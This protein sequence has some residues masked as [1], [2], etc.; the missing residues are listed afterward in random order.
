MAASFDKTCAIVDLAPTAK[1]LSY[2]SGR[3]WLLWPMWAYRVIVPQPKPE[4]LNLFQ[5]AV[6][7]LCRA[8][9][10]HAGEIAQ[11]L[12]FDKELAAYILDQLEGM[13]LLDRR[14]Q[15]TERA[16]QLLAEEPDDQVETT[17]G[18]V[19]A[20]PFIKELWPRFRRGVLPYAEGEIR[21]RFATIEQGTV[22][23]P[24][25]VE[26][27]VVW[28]PG[29]ACPPPP[30]RR[31]ILRACSMGIRAEVAYKRSM[32]EDSSTLD[33][34][35]VDTLK[36]HLNHVVLVDKT[37]EPMFLTTFV[38]VPK[39]VRR[40]S[41]W[42]VCDPFGLG[43]SHLLRKRIEEL[44]SAASQARGTLRDAIERATGVGF[45]VED[46]DVLD[47]VRAQNKKAAE[48]VDDKA[49]FDKTICPEVYERLVQM[50][51]KYLEAGNGDVSGKTWD[52]QQRRL[53]A[54]VR[55]AYI[56][57]E[58][59]LA[60]A[61]KTFPASDVWH[62]LGGTLEDNGVLLAE[63][64]YKI[65]FE[66]D[67]DD[68]CFKRFLRVGSGPVKGVIYHE[69]RELVALLAA[70]L[71][72]ANDRSEHPLRR[73]AAEFPEMIVFLNGLK[74]MR[75]QFSH[76]IQTQDGLDRE[77]ALGFCKDTYRVAQ[78]LLPTTEGGTT[79]SRSQF[80]SAEWNADI[81]YRL[82]AQA[83]YNVESDAL[84]GIRVQEVPALRDEL[85]E[86]ELLALELEKL[87]N[88]G[89]TPEEMDGRAKDLR[90]AAGNAVEAAIK[91]LL[92]QADVSEFITS[93]R[94]ANAERYSEAAEGLGFASMSDGQYH[95]DLLMVRPDRARLAAETQCGALNA[96]LMV[97]LLQAEQDTDHPLREVKKKNPRFLLDAGEVSQAR[98]HGDGRSNEA[99]GPEV[100]KK[101]VIAVGKAVLDVL[102]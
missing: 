90:V 58:E 100:L 93:D 31:D 101:H 102:T 89:A 45:A 29:D 43:T 19:F 11:R 35:N 96:L 91:P 67:P 33:G 47:L 46:V 75:D 69:Q 37:P 59:C 57:L 28:P 60:Y 83:A 72:A 77:E 41:L 7:S 18:Y 54:M 14:K 13:G 95:E 79:G 36:R 24:R 97:A 55:R 38:F 6:L 50:E 74:R 64:A 73:C 10:F 53:K 78:L 88:A 92:T 98:G 3:Q 8:G 80:S 68:P 70:A 62:P 87:R 63:I 34:L 66:D 56:V 61:V 49:D 26:M 40:A 4:R 32:E 42:Q 82:R 65:G 52:E 86:V 76:H 15:L 27:K 9:I 17:V 85:V 25:R 1:P 44:P 5:R 16:Y 81:V 71:L 48:V 21:G 84:F 23:N 30:S 94:N 22:G 99:I 51:N 12:Y 39:D 2:A 20:D